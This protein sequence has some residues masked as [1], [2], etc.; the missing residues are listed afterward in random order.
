M[1][2]TT[3][4]FEVSFGRNLSEIFTLWVESFK[5][6]IFEFSLVNENSWFGCEC[7]VLIILRIIRYNVVPPNE[8]ITFTVNA[9]NKFV[10]IFW[11][12]SEVDDSAKYFTIW[13]IHIQTDPFRGG[14][15]IRETTVCICSFPES[16][17]SIVN[18]EGEITNLFLSWLFEC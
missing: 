11:G 5:D 16:P 1:N 6:T 2:A 10:R 12:L 14:N 4:V 3:F 17:A 13:L 9:R 8:W 15:P 18:D 7:T